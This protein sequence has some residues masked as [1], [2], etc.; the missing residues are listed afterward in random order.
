[1]PAGWQPLRSG[2]AGAVGYDL[3]VYR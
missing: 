1:L 3:Y 2:A